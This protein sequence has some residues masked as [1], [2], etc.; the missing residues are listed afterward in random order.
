MGQSAS[1]PEDEG[2]ITVATGA[3][4]RSAS[5]AAAAAAQAGALHSLAVAPPTPEDVA[6]EAEA[7]RLLAHLA[8]LRALLPAIEAPAAAVPQAGLASFYYSSGAA[9]TGGWFGRGG[10]A[11]AAGGGAASSLS[12]AGPAAAAAAQQQQQ[13]QQPTQQQQ[14]QQRGNS[15]APRDASATAAGVWLDLDAARR[16]TDDTAALSSSL[17]ALVGEHRE[18]VAGRAQALLAGQQHLGRALERAAARAA[19]VAQHAR[20]QAARAKAAGRAL[21]RSVPLAGA[22]EGLVAQVEDVEARLGALEAELDAE[23]RAEEE[24]KAAAEAEAARAVR[25]GGGGASASASASALPGERR[26]LDAAPRPP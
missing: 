7:E 25:G 23:E 11:A 18:W 13:Q 5:S 8:Q 14:Q 6:A 1:T 17:G 19:A 9:A 22:L 10:A 16:L 4:G 15:G 24:E 12:S 3:A 2:I 21:A 26:E 20:A